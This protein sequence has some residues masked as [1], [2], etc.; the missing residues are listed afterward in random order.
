MSDN[1]QTQNAP[2]NSA[3]FRTMRNS[4]E[5]FGKVPN[6]A[7]PFRT[8]PNDAD[9]QENHTLTVRDVARIFEG[10]GV[11]RT[12]RSIINWCHPNRTG[13][14][15][16]D[17]YFDPND[18]KYYVTSESVELAVAE[19]KAKATMLQPELSEPDGKFP[20][21][22]KFRVGD[23]IPSEHSENSAETKALEQ[24]IID[25][26]ILNGSK[27]YFIEQLRKEREG[28]LAQLISASHKVG[29]LETRML[30][31]GA[32]SHKEVK[33]FERQMDLKGDTSGS[34]TAHVLDKE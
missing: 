30:Q 31:L 26:K 27:D 6:N 21:D 29:E 13:V 23:E 5:E 17:C 11:A 7:E 12:E 20:N 28:M 25:L 1:P 32:A 16:L 18:R 10:A 34:G 19:E 8:I 2:N 33:Q 24:E 4:A 3:P 14:A 15:R 9:R 22:P